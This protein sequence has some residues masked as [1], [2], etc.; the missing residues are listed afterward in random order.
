MKLSQV[1]LSLLVIEPKYCYIQG[2][3]SLAAVCLKLFYSSPA[4]ALL[5]LRCVHQ[6]LYTATPAARL[7]CVPQPPAVPSRPLVAQSSIASWAES[8]T[9][10]STAGT[11]TGCCGA[12]GGGFSF[13]LTA[14]FQL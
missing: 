3:D 13:F 6:T 7:P 12:C 9:R 11:R 10:G 14:Q 1:L 5:L 2:M 4:R 8:C